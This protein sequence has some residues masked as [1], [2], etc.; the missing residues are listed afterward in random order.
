MIRGTTPTHTFTIPFDASLIAKCRIIYAQDG[1]EI[2]CKNTEDCILVGQSIKTRL[3]QEETFSLDCKKCVEI[4][5][6]V[7]TKT[8]DALSSLVMKV[9]L[10]KCLDDEVLA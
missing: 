8:G 6:R 3:T 1:V 2:F 5:V 7:L 4:Q 10:D 9:G